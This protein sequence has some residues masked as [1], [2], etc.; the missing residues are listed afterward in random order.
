MENS[1]GKLINLCEFMCIILFSS[2]PIFNP[3]FPLA[4]H[5]LST[6]FTHGFPQVFSKPF[7][8]KSL[9]FFEFRG[10]FFSKFYAFFSA[11]VAKNE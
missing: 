5:T 11:G 10:D 3:H 9:S 1:C 8:K 2:A 6:V 4:F 7:F